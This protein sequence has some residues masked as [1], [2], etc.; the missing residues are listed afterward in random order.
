[1]LSGFY[2]P[3]LVIL[4]ALIGRGVAFEY[5][6]KV[7]DD[8]WRARW[9]LVIFWGSTLPAVVWGVIFANIV[10]G[11]ELNADHTV[12]SGLLELLNPYALLGGLTTLM[13][14]TT[15]GAVFLSLKTDGEVR[16]SARRVVRR[17]ALP[18][19]GVV[20]AFVVWT[21]AAHGAAWTV[22]LAVVVVAALMAGIML[23]ARSREG[24][25]F[26]ATALSI[27][28]LTV[29]LFGSLFPDVLPATDPARSLTV[30]NASAAPYAL[31]VMTWVAAAFLPLV[32]GYQTWS[33]WVFRKRVTRAHIEPTPAYA[34]SDPAPNEVAT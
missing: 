13:L 20:G 4:L 18:T 34:A 26:T 11:V 16:M 2:L 22:P 12:T 19:I 14:F 8:R 23:A 17:L 25:S 6:G 32:I 10:R 7:D 9:D 30:D 5:R 15:H 1:M 3:I 33:Y 31:T 24:W 27:A 21:Q 29:V 28:A